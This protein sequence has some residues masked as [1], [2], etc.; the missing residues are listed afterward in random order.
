MRRYFNLQEYFYKENFMFYNKFNFWG[1]RLC[2]LKKIKYKK[3]ARLAR[4][5]FFKCGFLE[6]Y[7]GLFRNFS[8][9]VV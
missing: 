1:K 5:S 7:K 3:Y 4:M 2:T 8:T 9:P 6:C